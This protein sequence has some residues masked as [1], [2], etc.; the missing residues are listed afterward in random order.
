MKHWD[1]F[2]GETVTLRSGG[3]V[4]RARF[5]CRDTCSAVFEFSDRLLRF[6]LRDDGTLIDKPGP[7]TLLT[8]KMVQGV[9]ERNTGR[10]AAIARNRRQVWTIEGEDRNTRGEAD[11]LAAMFLA[12]AAGR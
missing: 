4:V 12:R 6:E 2:P 11:E 8:S 10:M 3:S 9:A 1:L 5:L 7:D